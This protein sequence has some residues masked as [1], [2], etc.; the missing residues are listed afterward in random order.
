MTKIQLRKLSVV[1]VVCIWALVL[2]VHQVVGSRSL[3]S[4]SE[5]DAHES[6]LEAVNDR[7]LDDNI[8]VFD[9][10]NSG[11]LSKK[12]KKAN[13]K[14]HSKNPKKDYKSKKE[15]CKSYK[16][17]K[18]SKVKSNKGGKTKKGDSKNRDKSTKLKSKKVGKSMKVKSNKSKGKGS[19]NEAPTKNPTNEPS[20]TP[21]LMST[22]KPIL[23]NN[24]TEN[25]TNET[26][27]PPS[28]IS[29]GKPTLTNNP[30]IYPT[31]IPT[32]QP[33]IC[34]GLT[35]S[36]REN[37]IVAIVTELTDSDTFE[38]ET[39]PQSIA[40]DWI[41][42]IDGAQLCPDDKNTIKQR[43]TLAVVYYSTDGDNWNICSQNSQC[44]NGN[45]YLSAE[46]VCT[47]YRTTCDNNG[48]VL[49]V[50]LD[51]PNLG[52]DGSI[53]SEIFRLASLE[54]LSFDG[55]ANLQGTIP[56]SIAEAE[57]LTLLDLD[58]NNLIGVIP[59]SIGRVS[60]L[61]QLDID[62][63]SLTGIIPSELGSLSLLTGILIGENDYDA[64]SLPESFSQ[65][66]QLNFFSIQN[67]NI[68]AEIPPSYS[69]LRSMLGFDCSSNRIGGSIDVVT[70]WL[71]VQT[72][73]MN[74]NNFT[75]PISADIG[76]LDFLTA[77]R[78]QNNALTGEIPQTF[79][80]MFSLEVLNLSDNQLSGP[81]PD[82]SILPNLREL[83]IQDNNF[84]G[85][86][87]ASIC[88]LSLDVFN[89][90]CI[91]CD[92]CRD[93]DLACVDRGP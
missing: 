20:A 71:S 59:T 44:P 83:H 51:E 89:V 84:T 25:L 47:W 65:L 15:T 24:P 35:P 56:N 12:S 82:L 7:I 87:P 77:L 41:L 91:I 37:E 11:Q 4:T 85:Q 66:D 40:L 38:D 42:N 13:S 81:F 55:P 64:Q 52:I 72:L 9:L 33:T 46:D 57:S 43:Y 76:N 61:K 58:K 31:L 23:T 79:E 62:F 30:T 26:S 60:T 78:L 88:A 28:L 3:W 92:C 49:E 32:G 75:G 86:L 48:L 93:Q 36:S 18:K 69:Q 34:S 21:S 73:T 8:E 17:N 53:P 67:A 2:S 80:N 70:N 16:S 5:T 45:S 90:D 10:S 27:T 19:C 14:K 29:T 74:N 39:S 68:N 6:I 1:V 63:N 50:R 22:G 54:D